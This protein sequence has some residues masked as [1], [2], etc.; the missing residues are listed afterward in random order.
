MS[1]HPGAGY[2]DYIILVVLIVSLQIISSAH[3]AYLRIMGL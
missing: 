1:L 3:A 2:N